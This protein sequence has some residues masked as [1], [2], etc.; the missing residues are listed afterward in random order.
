MSIG[1]TPT[2]SP[3]TATTTP[4]SDEHRRLLIDGAAALRPLRSAAS[5]ARGSGATTL[6]IAAAGLP[7]SLATLDVLG[8]LVCAVLIAIGVIELRGGK[9]FLQAV[10]GTHLRLAINQL[11]L[12]AAITVYCIAQAVV[13]LFFS[14]Q[15][16][17][18]LVEALDK[19]GFDGTMI[20][21]VLTLV[22][23]GGV[24][25]AS[26]AFQGAMAFYYFTRGKAIHAFCDTTPDWVREVLAKLV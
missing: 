3:S 23:Y 26:V 21:R 9:A 22:V 2:P 8:I 1:T 25:A 18:I 11:A 14:G 24:I 7:I 12:L 13:V 10:P 5:V 16:T 17:A 15:S 4:L 19:Q 20:I 6:I